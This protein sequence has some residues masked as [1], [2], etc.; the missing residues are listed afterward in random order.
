[1]H[2]ICKLCSHSAS[3]TLRTV[4]SN[5]EV[6]LIG[7]QESYMPVCRECFNYKME[8]QNAMQ[9]NVV[10]A[11]KNTIAEIATKDETILTVNKQNLQT[12]SSNAT[13]DTNPTSDKNHSSK[14]SQAL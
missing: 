2:A 6:E 4:Q 10:E 12:P 5:S 9:N 14:A 1:M 13:A 7:G 3:F 8:E 11:T